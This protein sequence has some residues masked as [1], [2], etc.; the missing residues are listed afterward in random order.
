MRSFLILWFGLLG[1]CW[2]W[3]SVRL[4][5]LVITFCCS[6]FLSL[7][8]RKLPPVDSLRAE[9]VAGLRRYEGVSYYWGGEG[10]TGIDCSGLIR[11]GLIDSFFLRGIRTLDPGLVR[12]AFSLWW[13]D[14]T[15]RELGEAHDGL[16]VP[17]LDTP[18]VNSLTDPQL[19][20]GDLA[21]TTSGIHIMAYAGGNA[22]IEADPAAGRVISA[23]IPAP[24]ISWFNTPMRV[25][26][27][28]VLAEQ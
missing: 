24:N 9:Y 11:R 3:R 16:T 2:P 6:T 4:V 13:H 7:P 20:P 1:L 25:V 18:G 14:C 22:W 15:A 26:R 17:V 12:R 19:A 21:V 28:T 23:T 10:P 27:W 5:L 8:A